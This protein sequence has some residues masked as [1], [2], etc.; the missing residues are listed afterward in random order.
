MALM[1]P[2]WRVPGPPGRVPRTHLQEGPRTP[3]MRLQG[4][5]GWV[6]GPLWMGL[7][8]PIGWVPGPPGWV[9]RDPSDGSQDPRMGLQGPIGWVPGPLDGSQDP[10]MGSQDPRM[11]PRT[12]WM[13]PRTPRM[14]PRTPWMGP[15]DPS[16]GYLGTPGSIR[17]PPWIGYAR[18]PASSW[19]P[20]GV[21]AD[22]LRPSA[23]QLCSPG[24]NQPA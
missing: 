13:G 11:G 4:P 9:S 20:S 10:W 17:S 5:I 14:C 22:Q 6:P 23:G 19:P 2:V 15:W 18:W 8:G 24:A 16:D 21:T 12:P 7:Q 3:W 1:A